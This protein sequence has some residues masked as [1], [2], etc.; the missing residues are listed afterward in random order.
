MLIL[1][2]YRVSRQRLGGYTAS[3]CVARFDWHRPVCTVRWGLMGTRGY[4]ICMGW[5]Q[6]KWVSA[7]IGLR[8]DV[9]RPVKLRP[10]IPH[11]MYC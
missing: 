4:S 8:V 11:T 1:T 5:V 2:H 6:V 3:Y 10:N 9:H 7:G